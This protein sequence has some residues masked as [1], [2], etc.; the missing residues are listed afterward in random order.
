MTTAQ[1]LKYLTALEKDE[2]LS[3]WHFAL[4]T[5]ILYLGY[6]QGQNRIIKVSRSKIMALSHVNTLPTYHKYFKEL[7]DMGYIVYRPSY[8]PGYRSEVE[9]VKP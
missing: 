8:H 2:R 9:L 3:V 6:R 1:L 5:A 4:L 7:Q